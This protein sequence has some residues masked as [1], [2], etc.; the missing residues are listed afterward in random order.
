MAG[1]AARG[2]VAAMAGSAA[3]HGVVVMVDSALQP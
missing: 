1:S 3:A 2:V